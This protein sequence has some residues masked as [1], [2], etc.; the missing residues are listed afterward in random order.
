MTVNVYVVVQEI[1]DGYSYDVRD[2][3]GVFG[4]YKAALDY[5]GKRDCQVRNGFIVIKRTIT[6]N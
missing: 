6:T 2:F 3:A 4:T 1:T 5:I